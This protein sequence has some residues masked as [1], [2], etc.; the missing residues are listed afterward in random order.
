MMHRACMAK[1]TIS[2]DMEAYRRLSAARKEA[3]ESF[4]Q[5]IK[6]A[7][8]REEGKTCGALVAALPRMDTVDDEVLEIL[9][10]AQHTDLPPDNP[11]K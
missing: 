8:W 4:F 10:L 1:K 6:R 11:W 7:V 2:I 9:E 3:N 5:V